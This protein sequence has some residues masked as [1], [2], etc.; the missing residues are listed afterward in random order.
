[1]TYSGAATGS[2]YG[3]A[4]NGVIQTNGGGATYFPGNSAGSTS[5]GGQY[6]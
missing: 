2:R 6:N 5:V 1:V 3:A 4:L